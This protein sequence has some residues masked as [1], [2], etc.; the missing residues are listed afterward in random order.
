MSTVSRSKKLLGAM[1]TVLEGLGIGENTSPTGTQRHL[2]SLAHPITPPSSLHARFISCRQTNPQPKA[3][4]DPAK[5]SVFEVYAYRKH[6]LLWALLVS[7]YSANM[8]GPSSNKFQ[9][10]QTVMSQMRIKLLVNTKLPLQHSTFPPAN[11]M[12]P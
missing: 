6:H 9:L 3:G 5:W 12:G 1:S 11:H 2:L 10:I 8:H 4:G 7:N